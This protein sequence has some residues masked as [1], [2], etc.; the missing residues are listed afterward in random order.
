MTAVTI[1]CWAHLFQDRLYYYWTNIGSVRYCVNS[2]VFTVNNTSSRKAPPYVVA[3]NICLKC[4]G[5]CV[6]FFFFFSFPDHSFIWRSG[7]VYGLLVTLA[8]K[9]IIAP[10]LRLFVCVWVH[11]LCISVCGFMDKGCDWLPP[12]MRSFFNP[13]QVPLW[14]LTGKWKN[15]IFCEYMAH[16]HTVHILCYTLKQTH[17]YFKIVSCCDI[18]YT[19]STDL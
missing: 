3:T 5:P 18:Q 8:G 1:I 11:I 12:Q 16:S 17:I 10:G 7:P 13:S 4:R 14:M 6:Y 19:T 2:A 15:L 9:T